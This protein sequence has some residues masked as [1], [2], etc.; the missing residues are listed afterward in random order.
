MRVRPLLELCLLLGVAGEPIGRRLMVAADR[1]A[2]G[3][4]GLDMGVR[5]VSL[6]WLDRAT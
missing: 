3:V 6:G 4:A 2:T 1:R 5:F